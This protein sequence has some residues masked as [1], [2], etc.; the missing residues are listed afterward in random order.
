ML[1]LLYPFLHYPS[2]F[3][4]SSS[5]LPPF[6]TSTSSNALHRLP[7]CCVTP[8]VS[9][10]VGPTTTSSF[11]LLTSIFS[12]GFPNPSSRGYVS[13]HSFIHNPILSKHFLSSLLLS[14]ISCLTKPLP[15]LHLYRA[16]TPCKLIFSS[17]ISFFSK[18]SSPFL[19][20][21]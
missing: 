19:L 18:P 17:S 4:S 21:L 12:A 6:Y 1:F 20:F 16:H 3:T 14:T 11:T 8:Y 5:Y 9:T 2:D 13:I 7:F 10:I 15:L